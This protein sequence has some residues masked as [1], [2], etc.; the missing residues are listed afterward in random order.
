MVDSINPSNQ[1]SNV[2]SVGKSQGYED[3]KRTTS[4]QQQSSPVDEVK[5]SPEGQSLS[6][7]QRSANDAYKSLQAQPDVTLSSNPERLNALV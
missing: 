5:I 1:I 2:L 3:Q 6:E 4:P 7:A